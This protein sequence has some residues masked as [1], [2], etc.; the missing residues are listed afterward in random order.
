MKLKEQTQLDEL[1]A[2]G[3][4]G[5]VNDPVTAEGGTN[6]NRK[7]D[8]TGGESQI[9]SGTA[10][11]TPGQGGTPSD[12]LKT[13][14]T[15]KSPARRGDKTV[16][17]SVDAMF[18]GSDLSEEFKEK[19]T[20]IF[21]AA[22]AAKL[23]EEV[24]RLEEEYNS[25]LEEEVATISEQMTE[26]VDSYLDYVVKEWMEENK[27]AIDRGIR[28]EVMESF[29]EGLYTLFAEHNINVEEDEIDVV[30]DM[31]EELEAK[32]AALNESINKTI[33]L[34]KEIESMKATAILEGYTKGL[35][36]TQAEKLR[37]L[38]ENVEFADSAE[39]DNKVK[40]IKEQYFGSKK[41][42][43]E[44]SDNIDPVDVDTDSVRNVD[45]S[46][47]YYAEAI[48]KTIRKS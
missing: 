21:E 31:V 28:M 32:D 25:K 44:A 48:S 27:V 45:P 29:M 2:S 42:L 47:A 18:E 23:Q 33:E 38:A 7:A 26:K 37:T 41:V 46:V 5:E 1:K 35:T 13:V 6:M 11:A 8:K 17:E 10:V 14:A 15:S 39:F 16:G 22:V 3:D 19:A 12:M 36:E 9:G 20:V 30:A 43:S 34:T 24:A 40:I 4:A